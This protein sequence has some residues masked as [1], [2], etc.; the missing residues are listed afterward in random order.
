ML[1]AIHVNLH[2]DYKKHF[3][4][5]GSSAFKSCSLLYSKFSC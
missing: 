5:I 2:S 3:T 1:S 4:E